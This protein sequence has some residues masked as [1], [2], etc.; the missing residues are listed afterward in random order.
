MG[1][2]YL[3][4][5]KYQELFKELNRLKKVERRNIAKE[6][7]IA[8]DKGDLREN[9]EYDAAKEKQAY[10]EK[11]IAEVEDK[12]S[13]VEFVD[14]LDIDTS[15]INIG[16]KVELEDV[17]TKEKIIYEL[18]GPDEADFDQNKISVTSPVGRGLIDH[19]KGEIVQIQVPVGVLEYKVLSLTYE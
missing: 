19:K 7:G 6:I 1:R 5:K 17:K 3:T 4:Q 9:A 14:N 13:R 11:R 18:V 15:K 12:L 2:V 16:A 10:V 8:R